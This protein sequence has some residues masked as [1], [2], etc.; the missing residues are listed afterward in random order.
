MQ[1]FKITVANSPEGEV[2]WM[3]EWTCL[4]AYRSVS[5]TTKENISFGFIHPSKYSGV[6]A[7]FLHKVPNDYWKKDSKFSFSTLENEIRGYFND[8]E[9]RE[10]LQQ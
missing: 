4:E 2:E 3:I 10:Q 6:F 7:F 8:D 5:N 9:K 1:T